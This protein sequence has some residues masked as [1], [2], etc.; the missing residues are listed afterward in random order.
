MS[1]MDEMVVPVRPMS[2]IDANNFG[3]SF[4]RKHFPEMLTVPQALDVARLVEDVLPSEGIRVYAERDLGSYGVTR[5]ADADDSVEILLRVNL[6]DALFAVRDR[7]RFFAIS[8]LVHEVAHGLRHMPQFLPAH[9]RA[10]QLGHRPDFGFTLH[11]RAQLKPYKDPEWQAHAIGGALVAPLSAINMLPSHSVSELA[12]V[13]GISVSNMQAQLK[14]LTSKG[15]V[16]ERPL[17]NPLG[18]RPRSSTRSGG[19][20][21]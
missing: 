15:L 8:T 3:E 9:K 14:R 1:M 19:P 12:K 20:M 2:T 13:F 11:C 6:F 18:S 4:L 21:R 17:A 16:S 7:N 5:F 10:K